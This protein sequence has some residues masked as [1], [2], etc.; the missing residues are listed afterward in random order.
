MNKRP[1]FLKS[2]QGKLASEYHGDTDFS[3][4]RKESIIK[5][6]EAREQKAEGREF[7]WERVKDAGNK[8]EVKKSICWKIDLNNL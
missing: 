6:Q 3:R 1:R 4:K 5:E 8:G 7:G 2:R